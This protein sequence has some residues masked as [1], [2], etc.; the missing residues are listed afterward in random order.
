MEIFLLGAAQKTEIFP[1]GFFYVFFT[2][3]ERFAENVV[4][5]QLI[6]PS[7]TS[8]D[9]GPFKSGRVFVRTTLRVLCREHV[10][11]FAIGFNALDFKS[12]ANPAL[13]AGGLSSCRL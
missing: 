3:A 13:D 7:F 12:A 10:A 1:F 8:S 2:V 9:R 4:L 5:T 11:K 6:A